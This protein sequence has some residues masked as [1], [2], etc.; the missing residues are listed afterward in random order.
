MDEEDVISVIS[1]PREVKASINQRMEIRN[2]SLKTYSESTFYVHCAIN[3]IWES[4]WKGEGQDY[5][6]RNTTS[7]LRS[8]L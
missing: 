1:T 5:D 3:D 6:H 7:W 8:W 2:D 4:S